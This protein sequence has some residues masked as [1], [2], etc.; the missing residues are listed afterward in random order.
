MIS[1]R[2]PTDAQLP[3][4]TAEM[5]SAMEHSRHLLPPVGGSM[6]SLRYLAIVFETQQD[7]DECGGSRIKTSSIDDT[8]IVF[9]QLRMSVCDI[10]ID[11]DPTCL[12]LEENTICPMVQVHNSKSTFG[13][14]F[15]ACSM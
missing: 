15:V 8:P 5:D 1:S 3:V 14:A 10:S 9:F 12:D 2:I 7:E 13:L 4:K 6:A 11:K